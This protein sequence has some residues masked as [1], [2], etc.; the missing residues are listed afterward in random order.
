MGFGYRTLA[1]GI[2][3]LSCLQLPCTATLAAPLEIMVEDAAAPWSQKDGTGY[4]N[5]IVRAAYR[6][7]GIDI[8][9]RVVPYARCKR[10]VM[11]GSAAGCFNMSREQENAR[12]VIF[13]K[14]PLF[15]VWA[16]YFYSAERP[17]A[18]RREA[19]LPSGTR[20]GTVLGYEYPQSTAGLREQGVVF[21]AAK[22]EEDNLRKLAAGRID[23]A[24]INL[25][26]SKTASY[27]VARAGA[28]GKV[29]RAFRSSPFGSYIGFSRRNPKGP[30]A[31]VKFNE[32]Y[33]LLRKSG[34]LQ[35]IA[36]RWHLAQGSARQ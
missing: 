23:A 1:V 7:V 35:R 21:E 33:E 9:L 10:M 6:A 25:D 5:D 2:V 36:L 8:S 22:S 27:I 34:E 12:D 15:T 14:T 31:C 4:A 28:D 17:L 29:V 24:I 30:W 18:A 13:A 19:E 26:E 20:V 3:W 32:G 16:Q 11:S